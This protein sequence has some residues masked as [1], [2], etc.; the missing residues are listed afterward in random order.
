MS[1]VLVDVM[2][3]VKTLLE[4]N[5][6]ESNGGQKPSILLKT[7]TKGLR[8]DSVVIYTD[9]EDLNYYVLGSRLL[10]KEGTIFLNIYTP[11][12]YS[13]LMEIVNEVI[14]ILVGNAGEGSSWSIL[15]VARFQD[16]SNDMIKNYRALLTVRYIK[17]E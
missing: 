16:L 9:S 14:R 5:W 15:S 12:S 3:E 7:E 1:S 13:R 2:N 11:T 10:R 17:Y 6:D 8:N 4:N